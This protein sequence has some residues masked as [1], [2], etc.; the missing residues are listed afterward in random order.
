MFKRFSLRG[1]IRSRLIRIAG[2]LALSTV[3]TWAAPIV[4]G[5]FQSELANL[6][7][8]D[9][10]TGWFV[11]GNSDW[12]CVAQN[13]A[14]YSC[15]DG[16]DTK[17]PSP[18]ADGS[19][20]YRVGANGDFP[21]DPANP[22]METNSI[23]EATWNDIVA[24]NYNYLSQTVA[25]SPGNNYLLTFQLQALYRLQPYYG[26]WV[27]I[28]HIPVANLSA[29]TQSSPVL[30]TDTVN[31]WATFQIPFASIGPNTEI[32]FASFVEC[33]RVGCDID[34]FLDSV[35]LTDLGSAP[36][37]S[38]GLLLFGGLVALVWWRRS[39]KGTAHRWI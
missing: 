34:L 19:R 15:G 4:N 37:V 17:F 16:T 7:R 32:G 22:D 36:E 9:P 35:S 1:K 5:S 20:A 18:A 29:R 13:T 27:V 23:Y 25:T 14:P 26:F 8:G 10:I 38:S 39:R 33:N 6:S 30:R 3:S 21:R 24:L 11:S 2:A 31:R 28:D 12:A